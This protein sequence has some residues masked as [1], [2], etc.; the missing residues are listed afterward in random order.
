MN[1]GWLVAF[2]ILIIILFV[3]IVFAVGMSIPCLPYVIV[4]ILLTLP[5]MYVAKKAF[6]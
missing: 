3:P 4:S 5:L 6:Y 1:I 2:I